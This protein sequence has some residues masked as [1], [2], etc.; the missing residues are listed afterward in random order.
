[1]SYK[2]TTHNYDD[3]NTSFNDAKDEKVGCWY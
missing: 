1:M 2:K 3:F